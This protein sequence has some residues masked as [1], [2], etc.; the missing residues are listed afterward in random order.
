MP[1]KRCEENG[2][3][4]GDQGKCY[5][6]KD[7][8]KK[9]I[10]QGLAIHGPEKFSDEIRKARVQLDRSEIQ[11]V[12]DWME[13]QKYGFGDIAVTNLILSKDISDD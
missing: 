4:W 7:A 11:E 3:R 10:K 8:K 5:H 12:L 2:W 1:L 13:E 9:A 6:G